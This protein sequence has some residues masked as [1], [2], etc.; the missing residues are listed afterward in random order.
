M[1]RLAAQIGINA[2]NARK[3]MALTQHEVAERVDLATE[4]YG[5]IERGGMMPSVGTLVRI[6]QA[7]ETTPDSLLG[8]TRPTVAKRK[9]RPELLRLIRLLEHSSRPQLRRVLTVV[10]AMMR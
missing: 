6:A 4:V 5:R 3:A 1:D 10:T 8:F 9:P 2:R 7:L